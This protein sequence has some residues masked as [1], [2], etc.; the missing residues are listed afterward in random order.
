M[1]ASTGAQ[2]APAPTKGN[3]YANASAAQ[4]TEGGPPAA[5]AQAVDSHTQQGRGSHQEGS[6]EQAQG[7]PQG[8]ARTSMSVDGT[9]SR[10]HRR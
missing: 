8:D 9:R 1:N 6:A 4:P 5:G 10:L 2:N 7:P 3:S